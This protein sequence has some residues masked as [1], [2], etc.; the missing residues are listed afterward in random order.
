MTFDYNGG[1][2]DGKTELVLPYDDSVRFPKVVL[3][4]QGV[5]FIGWS[6]KQN[7]T[8]DAEIFKLANL[9][10]DNGVN[11]DTTTVSSKVTTW[12]DENN[13]VLYAVWR[14]ATG[15][16]H[17]PAKKKVLTV[18][19]HANFDPNEELALD[20]DPNPLLDDMDDDFGFEPDPLP[21][22]VLDPTVEAVK[23]VTYQ[24]DE[25]IVLRCLSAAATFLW[26][27]TQNRTAQAKSTR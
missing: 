6:T 10:P 5:D 1:T 9:D 14:S 17:A 25:N 21:E 22:D 24:P 2:S 8:S 26:A 15:P 12:P 4:K 13:K 3:T 19:Y 18:H 11:P 16:S 20:L 27:G 23:T 7:P